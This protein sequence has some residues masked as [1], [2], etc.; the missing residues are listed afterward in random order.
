[1]QKTW[2][3]LTVVCCKGRTTLFFLWTQAASTDFRFCCSIPFFWLN[4]TFRT[5][6]CFSLESNCTGC[7][8]HNWKNISITSTLRRTKHTWDYTRNPS[9]TCGNCPNRCARRVWILFMIF[10]WCP[11]NVTPTLCSK[12]CWVI[13]NTCS[14]VL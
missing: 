3:N 4:V 7:Q 14:I 6:L 10:F 11:I 13:F 9:E 2:Q 8:H 5:S 1:M 12:S